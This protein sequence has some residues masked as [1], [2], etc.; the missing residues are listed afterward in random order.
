MYRHNLISLLESAIR[1]SNAQYDDADVLSRLCVRV[2]QPSPGDQGWDV[3][4]LDYR[5]DSPL[6]VVFTKE[7]MERYLRLFN[8]LWRLKRLEHCLAVTWKRHNSHAA[9]L[10]DLDA[11]PSIRYRFHCVALLVEY[12]R[13]TCCSA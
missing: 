2:L 10:R 6:N 13:D 8:F 1:S 3:F 9:R 5:V 12:E 4:S 11:I 7:S